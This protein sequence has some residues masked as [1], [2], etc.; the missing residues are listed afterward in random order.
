MST[1]AH[2]KINHLLFHKKS[3]QSCTLC[4]AVTKPETAQPAVFSEN[5]KHHKSVRRRRFPVK[6]AWSGSLNM[7]VSH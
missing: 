5:M 2:S 4:I 1:G 3:F 7:Q 6:D